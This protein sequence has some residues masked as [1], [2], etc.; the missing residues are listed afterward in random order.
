MIL[1][2]L[3]T[4]IFKYNQDLKVRLL[5]YLYKGIKKSMIN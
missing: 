5:Y 2:F 3:I 4:I 1:T